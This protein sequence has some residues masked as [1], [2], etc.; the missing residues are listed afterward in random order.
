VPPS[1][2]TE[3]PIP[4]ELDALVLACLSKQPDQRPAAALELAERLTPFAER[5][6]AEHARRWWES[7]LPQT[8]R[9]S[10]PR[11]QGTLVPMI[12]GE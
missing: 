11:T 3:L 8:P 10:T 12:S 2:R 6:T 7:H 9:T 5:W 1:R 4:P